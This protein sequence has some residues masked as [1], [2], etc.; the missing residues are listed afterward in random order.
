VF[1]HGIPPRGLLAENMALKERVVREVGHE[2]SLEGAASAT[3]IKS[4][5]ARSE[6]AVPKV[7]SPSA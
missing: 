6:P 7:E 1:F 4:K 2:L 3:L 5:P